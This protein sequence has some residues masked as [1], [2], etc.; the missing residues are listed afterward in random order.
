MLEGGFTFQH[1]ALDVSSDPFGGLA[2]RPLLTAAPLILALSAC[3]PQPFDA[4]TPWQPLSD[5]A[6]GR[7]FRGGLMASAP[8]NVFDEFEADAATQSGQSPTGPQS[9]VP[10]PG[11]GENPWATIPENPVVTVCYG[12]AVNDMAEVRK[13]AER[14]CPAGARLEL[15]RT[16]TFLSDC[17]LLQPTR[18][19]FRCWTDDPDRAEAGSGQ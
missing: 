4:T 19:A 2:V 14:L 7:A 3:A 9:R 13:T 16:G 10:D 15:I 5:T 11:S 18:A 8:S 1:L 17:P 6:E 12:A